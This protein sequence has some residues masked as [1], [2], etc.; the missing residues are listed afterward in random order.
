M[1]FRA[2]PNRAV[3][4]FASGDVAKCLDS[5]QTAAGLANDGSYTTYATKDRDGVA[6]TV[7]VGVAVVMEGTHLCMA[8]RGVEKQ[9]SY[10]VTSAM[11]GAFRDHARTRSEFL[12]FIDIRDRK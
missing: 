4:N 10:T 1:R 8:M 3:E 11:L 12:T 6:V 9:N 5:A 2:I 7:W